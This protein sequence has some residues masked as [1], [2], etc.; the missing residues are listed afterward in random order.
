MALIQIYDFSC[1]NE[2]IYKQEIYQKYM[3]NIQAIAK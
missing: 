1:M 2:N 3:Q